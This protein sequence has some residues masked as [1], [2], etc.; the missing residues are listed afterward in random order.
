MLLA[1]AAQ[2]HVDACPMEGFV[3]AEYDTVLGLTGTGYH[4]ALVV[5]VGYR[6]AE[7]KYAHAPKVRKSA[8]Q[9]I[10]VRG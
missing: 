4:T 9:V 6:S 3:A 2:L 10:Q 8:D 5:P 1:T 7:D